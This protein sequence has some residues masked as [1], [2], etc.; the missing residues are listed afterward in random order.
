[1]SGR[2]RLTDE[3]LSER[4]VDLAE[5]DV[6]DVTLGV[7]QVLGRPVLVVVGVPRHYE[8]V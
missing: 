1:V 3:G 2:E 6:A 8:P 5:V 4:V 7:D